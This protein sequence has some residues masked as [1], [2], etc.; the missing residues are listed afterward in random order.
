M[1]WSSDL[2][3]HADGRSEYPANDGRDKDASVVHDVSDQ[4][5]PIYSS[6]ALFG[7]S[8]LISRQRQ[9][10]EPRAITR[11]S[12]LGHAVDRHDGHSRSSIQL[13]G[14]PSLRCVVCI[15]TFQV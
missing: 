14:L 10:V 5:Q 6:Y 7:E 2:D 15:D 12:H 8:L 1:A 9:P 13:A 11:R 3:G 4:P